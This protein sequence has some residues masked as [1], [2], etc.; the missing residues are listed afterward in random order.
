MANRISKEAYDSRALSMVVY[1]TDGSDNKLIV[2][3]YTNE[4]TKRYQ[5]RYSKNCLMNYRAKP[6][7]DVWFFEPGVTYPKGE[8]WGKMLRD[9][10]GWRYEGGCTYME[11]L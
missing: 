3:H 8:A 11:H 2:H 4:K 1:H 10:T 7:R 6:I 5:F 9:E